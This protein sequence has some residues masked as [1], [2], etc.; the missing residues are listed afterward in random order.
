LTQALQKTAL[1]QVFQSQGNKTIYDQLEINKISLEESDLS[2]PNSSGTVNL[3]FYPSRIRKGGGPSALQPIKI[4]TLVSVDGS[5]KIK[6]CNAEDES[7]GGVCKVSDLDKVPVAQSAPYAH[8]DE[9][10]GRGNGGVPLN[11]TA[12]IP[13]S[14]VRI[15]VGAQDKTNVMQGTMGNIN[16]FYRGTIRTNTGTIFGTVSTSIPVQCDHGKWCRTDNGSCF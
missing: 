7:G 10:V 11:K 8:T 2:A 3:A 16:A 5:Y 4:K 12:M 6:S 15:T 14:S 1:S 13:L 9:T